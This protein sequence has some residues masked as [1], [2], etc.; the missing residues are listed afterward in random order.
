MYT[1]VY[2][3]RSIAHPQT[4]WQGYSALFDALQT[5]LIIIIIIIIIIIEQIRLGWHKPKLRG[6][7]TDVTKI[8]AV[9][10]VREAS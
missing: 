6:H 7:L 2:Y 10:S 4:N 9:A 5:W 1:S 3:Y 8:H